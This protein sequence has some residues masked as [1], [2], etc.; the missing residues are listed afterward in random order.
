MRRARFVVVVARY[1]ENISWV[2]ELLEQAQWIDRVYV[3]NKG[4]RASADRQLLG[5]PP[6][7]RNKVEVRAAANTGREGGTYLDFIA[8][9]Y[10]DL[11]EHL[12]FLQADPFTH[13]PDLLLF[14]RSGVRDQYLL[15]GFQALTQSYLVEQNI[16]PRA[17][18]DAHTAYFLHDADGDTEVRCAE[19]FI[20]ASSLQLRGHC[21]FFDEGLSHFHEDAFRKMAERARVTP[22]AA[23]CRFHFSACFYVC[24]R[25]VKQHPKQVYA[26]LHSYL[27]HENTQGGRCGYVLERFWN[28]LFTG[29]SYAS[30]TDCYAQ[31]L[32]AGHELSSGVVAVHCAR[33]QRL[34]LKRHQPAFEVVE[35][36]HTAV[37]FQR[38][39]RTR[40]LPCIDVAGPPEVFSARCASREAA[41]AF[42]SA[43]RTQKEVRLLTYF[44]RRGSALT[45]RYVGV[46][47]LHER[48]L[49]VRKLRAEE[50][51]HAHAM[52]ARPASRAL[53][54]RE[55]GSKKLRVLPGI[56]YGGADLLVL[57]C[58]SLEKALFFFAKNA[59]L[60]HQWLA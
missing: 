50:D 33:R 39:G 47:C 49:F 8:G 45:L 6:A 38:G 3:V 34:W 32:L 51:D 41:S 35:D 11:P 7:A 56:D 28:Y 29:K 18:V 9:F 5:M 20:D 19:Y 40:V 31:T 53:I 25:L 26:D 43:S 4:E 10:E 13:S 36:E 17:L 60:M 21:K 30:L 54:F 58:G 44:W 27:L 42:F 22:P 16:P 59:K 55:N 23:F 46:Y 1:N 15:Q 24:A 12:W 57:L 52:E 14:F 48:K 2:R 37:L